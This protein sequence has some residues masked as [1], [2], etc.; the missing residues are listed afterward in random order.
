MDA[1]G[2][3][4]HIKSKGFDSFIAIADNYDP[5]IS[6]VVRLME[7]HGGGGTAHGKR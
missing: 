4:D 2:I 6:E 7:Y 5:G 1:A 3:V